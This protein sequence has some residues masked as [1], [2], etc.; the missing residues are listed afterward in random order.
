MPRSAADRFE[1]SSVS[2]LDGRSSISRLEQRSSL[3]RLDR[4]SLSRASVGKG[5]LGRFSVAT[6]ISAASSAAT[7]HWVNS[8]SD[9]YGPDEIEDLLQDLHR[10]E[11][12]SL[13][14]EDYREFEGVGGSQDVSSGGG[15]MA[16][17]RLATS[18]R[19]VPP[20]Q[21]LA[22]SPSSSSCTATPPP[23]PLSSDSPVAVARLRPSPAH[24]VRSWDSHTHYHQFKE[25]RASIFKNF[26]RLPRI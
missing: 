3:T 6:D 10:L 17:R 20:Q 18:Y 12:A 24:S 9:I 22:G 23:P 14:A 11:L 1:R 2:R 8:V 13:D 5:S 25:R 4:S 15:G 19:T 21:Q 26:H 16:L 7:R